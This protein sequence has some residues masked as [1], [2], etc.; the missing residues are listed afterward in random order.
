MTELLFA[1]LE[2]CVLHRGAKEFAIF[3][4]TCT[5]ASQLPMFEERFEAEWWEHYYNN[6]AFLIQEWW[7]EKRSTWFYTCGDCGINITRTNYEQDAYC[8]ECKDEI[9]NQIIEEEKY[10]SRRFQKDLSSIHQDRCQ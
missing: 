9:E 1:A 8:E 4:T 7:R 10:F 3:R 2:I 5:I 6:N